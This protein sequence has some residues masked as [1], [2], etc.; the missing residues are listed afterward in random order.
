MSLMWIIYLADSLTPAKGTLM[1]LL[2]SVLLMVL[3]TALIIIMRVGDSD[4]EEYQ[5]AKKPYKYFCVFV[6]VIF[7]YYNLVPS[8]ETV[9]KMLAAY[10]VEKVAENPDVRRLA[11]RSLDVLEKAMDSYVKD[12]K[13]KE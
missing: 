8:K 4:E 7:L 2:L 5:K 11:G 3:A 10:G 6:G 12:S 1:L 13:A 9:Y